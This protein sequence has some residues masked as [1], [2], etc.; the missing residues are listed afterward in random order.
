MDTRVV[1]MQV[2]SPGYA[3][4]ALTGQ[5]RELEHTVLEM[6][7]RAE[8]MVGGAVEAVRALDVDLA[9]DVISKDDEIDERDLDIENRCLRLLALQQPAAGDL[10]TVGT[11]MKMITDLERIGD[12]AVD[13]AKIALKIEK[14]FGEPNFIDLPRMGNEARAMLRTS[15][16]AFVRCDLLLVREVVDRDERVDTLYRQ[17][18]E[19]IFEHMRAHPENVIT[20]GWL[21][22]A[23]HHIERVADHAV[24]IA[25][26]VNFMV[27]GEFKQ[28]TSDDRP[29]A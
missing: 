15:M 23:I 4:Q 5:I 20:G 28:L 19:Q 27:T 9:R 6:G 16:D 13:I 25:E 22:L 10:R 18:R 1:Q 12:L 14:D 26:R 17:L 2:E 8:A 21:L 11:I 29:A 7:S 24:N 3:R